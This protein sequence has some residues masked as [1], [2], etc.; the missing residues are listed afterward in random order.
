M[1]EV[2]KIVSLA[3]ESRAKKNIKVRQPL[4]RLMLRTDEKDIVEDSSYIALIMDEVNVKEVILNSAI[5]D[6]VIL[7][8]TL[9]PDLIMEGTARELIRF[10][11]DM[12]KKAGLSPK[13]SIILTVDTDAEGKKVV[14]KFREEITRTARIADILFEKAP[15]GE[16]LESFKILIKKI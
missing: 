13:D 11:Q 2:R 16:V 9:N 1:I 15:E 4:A 8:I 6:E 10:I 5:T 7:D 12:R 3:L 14:D